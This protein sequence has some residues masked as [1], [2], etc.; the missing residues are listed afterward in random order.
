MNLTIAEQYSNC[1][2]QSN[3]MLI[4]IELQMS[5][6]LKNVGKTTKN[7]IWCWRTD[8]LQTICLWNASSEHLNWDRCGV[9]KTYY[10]Q[11]AF[12]L[13]FISG[14]IHFM[15]SERWEVDCELW[16]KYFRPRP[17]PKSA[18]AAVGGSTDLSAGV[19][20][21]FAPAVQSAL[22]LFP[23]LKG[24]QMSFPPH[25]PV[26]RSPCPVCE[27]EKTRCQRDV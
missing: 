17:L 8:Y 25:E 11:R 26:L 1:L 24:L 2:K 10:N 5:T 4:I 3:I 21:L 22:S 18:A 27:K 16:H 7:K 14:H 12:R 13:R 15:K 23:A 9:T 6:E 19:E 20:T